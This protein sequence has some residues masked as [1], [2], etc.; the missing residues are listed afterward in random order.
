MENL[1][2]CFQYAYFNFLRS[3]FMVLADNTRNSLELTIKLYEFQAILKEKN[4]SFTWST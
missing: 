2:Y 1:Q 3:K 4:S